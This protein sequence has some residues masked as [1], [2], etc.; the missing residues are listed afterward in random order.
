LPY[1]RDKAELEFALKNLGSLGLSYLEVEGVSL[2]SA[3]TLQ[4]FL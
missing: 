2:G 4:L 1:F 3:S